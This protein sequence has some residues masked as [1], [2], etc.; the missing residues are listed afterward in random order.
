MSLEH[1]LEMAREYSADIALE[2]ERG[3]L[4][5]RQLMEKV[6][7]LALWLSGQPVS[8]VGLIADNSRDWVLVDLASQMAGRVCLPIPAFFSEEQTRHCLTGVDLLISDQQSVIE[9]PVSAESV[10]VLGTRLFAQHIS[11]PEGRTCHGETALPDETQKITFTSGSTGNPKGVCLSLKHQWQVAQSL[12]EVI[13]IAQPRHLCLLPLATLLENIAGIYVPLLCGGRVILPDASQRGLSG[14]SGLDLPALLA[15]IQQ[16]KPNTLILLPQLLQALVVAC[17]QGWQPPESLTF[18]AVGGGKVAPSLIEQARRAGLPVYEGYGLS[19]CAS[20]VALN[21]PGNDQPGSVGKCLPHCQVTVEDDEIVV[22]GASFLGYMGQPESWYPQAVRTSDLGSVDGTWLTIHGRKK[23]L[24]IS[25]FGRNISPEWVESAVL[26]MPLMT[27]CVVLG[28]GKPNLVALVSAADAVSDE[29]IRDWIAS[30][31]TSLPDYA[32]IKNWSRL[33]T[34]VWQPY[35]T[36]NGRPRR[37]LI[38]K[39]FAG[40]VED[41]YFEHKTLNVN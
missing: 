24:L 8:V 1:F 7:A 41:L 26:A 16:H 38:A 32:R 18:M 5:Y 20:V 33:E 30:V 12:A 9:T 15:C 34:A 4:S 35:L 3:S 14:S 36:A 22:S 13:D 40:L 2:D 21:T 25:S 17:Q 29:A 37:D 31:N 39:D 19:E 6:E 28:D 10:S 23:N 11:Q 27:Q